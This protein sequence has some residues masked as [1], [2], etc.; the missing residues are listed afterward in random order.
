MPLRAL[1]LKQELAH[2]HLGELW[3]ERLAANRLA[4]QAACSAYVEL[5]ESVVDAGLAAFG[6][7]AMDQALY[8]AGSREH[9]G[10]MRALFA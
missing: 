1:I 8:L 3:V 7:Y 9:L 4:L 10:R 5:A 2:Q 6:N